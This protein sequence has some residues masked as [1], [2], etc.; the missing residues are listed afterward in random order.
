[1]FRSLRGSFLR[2][3]GAL[4]LEFL[5]RA[6][7]VLRSIGKSAA[8]RARDEFHDDPIILDLATVEVVQ[9]FL[10][11]EAFRGAAECPGRILMALLRP[12]LRR[13]QTRR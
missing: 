8:A 11:D 1:M 7:S 3:S 10:H 13:R 12:I 2:F 9:D 5:N 4:D 6:D